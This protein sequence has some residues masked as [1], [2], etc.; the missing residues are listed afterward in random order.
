MAK[1][2]YYQEH[3]DRLDRGENLS[4]Q[5]IK[6]KLH[7]DQSKAKYLAAGR[8]LLDELNE[9]GFNIVAVQDLRHRKTKYL[10]AIPILIK[11]LPKIRYDPLRK[12]IVRTLSVSWAKSA[13]EVLIKEFE[14]STG[15]NEEDYRWV[16]G[17]ALAAVA[18]KKYF[19]ELATIVRDRSAGSA[20]QMV[21]T[22]LAK[23][24]HPEAAGIL[25]EILQEGEEVGHVLDALRHLKARVPRELVEPYLNHEFPW[26]RK[27]A[28]K[29]LELQDKLD[30]QEP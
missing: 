23:T 29:L 18:H 15:E 20:R 16:V 2:N 3:L 4:P 26:V 10:D 17:N 1:R 25:I 8:G 9:S 19:P 11:W 6:L 24:K 7:I 12:D 28:K 27:E 30:A 21:M 14:K 13:T 22:A 5:D